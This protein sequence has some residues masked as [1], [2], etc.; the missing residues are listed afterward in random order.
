ML[1]DIGYGLVLLTLGMVGIAKIKEGE[2]RSLS[3]LLVYCSIS[4]IIFGILYAEIFGFHIFGHHSIVTSLM[5]ENSVLGMAFH[6]FSLLPIL[7]RLDPDDIPILLIA[8]ALIGVVHLNL[9][10]LLGFRNMAISHGMKEAVLE[11]MSWIVLQLGIAIVIIA[12]IGFIPQAGQ[13]IG[14]AVAVL[15]LVMLIAG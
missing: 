2:L 14:A 8:S 9:G 11:K 13:I 5:G 10:F 15:G 6:N 12:Y 3:T 4:T 7:D 1:G